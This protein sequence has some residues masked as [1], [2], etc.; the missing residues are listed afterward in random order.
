MIWRMIDS[1]GI[2]SWFGLHVQAFLDVLSGLWFGLWDRF[3]P[4]ASGSQQPGV[5]IAFK[6]CKARGLEGRID[7]LPAMKSSQT[8]D[9]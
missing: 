4:M 1:S 8:F 5:P 2:S 3:F 9:N 7:A 6:V